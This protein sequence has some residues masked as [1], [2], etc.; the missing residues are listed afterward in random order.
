MAGELE[1]NEEHEHH[2]R[3]ERVRFVGR[4]LMALVV[5]AA[6]AGAFGGGP[7]SK[8][9]IESAGAQ[10]KFD[11]LARY[12]SPGKFKLRIPPGS[13]EIKL[14]VNN[15]LLDRITIE[16]ID[17]EPKELELAPGKQ[18]WSFPI[19]D[20]NGPVE[21]TIDYRPDAFGKTQGQ[22][23]IEGRGSLDFNQFYFP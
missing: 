12:N 11:R 1:L 17:P 15:A 10:L 7:G 3:A 14:S 4:A 2:R 6:L 22:L 20:T 21:I 19:F 23:A 5:I 8:G 16:R 9:E 18:I 13:Q